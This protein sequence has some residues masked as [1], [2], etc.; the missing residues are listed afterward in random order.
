MVLSAKNVIRSSQIGPKTIK[1]YFIAYTANEKFK[2][3]G[4]HIFERIKQYTTVSVKFL[5]RFSKPENPKIQI[6]LDK[7]AVY[8]RIDL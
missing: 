4:K 7:G 8:V 3:I 1:L 2:F 5:E 6:F